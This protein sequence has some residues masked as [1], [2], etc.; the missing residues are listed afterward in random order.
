MNWFWSKVDS[1][2]K[3]GNPKDINSNGPWNST[4]ILNLN[5]NPNCSSIH[6]IFQCE[7]FPQYLF[8]QTETFFKYVHYN[9]T[10]FIQSQ[11]ITVC[12][13]VCMSVGLYTNTHTNTRYVIGVWHPLLPNHCFVIIISR[14]TVQCKERT[15]HATGYNIELHKKKPFQTQ[16]KQ[17]TI[18]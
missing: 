10:M 4:P 15:E 1:Q 13:C 7:K 12:L 3:I 14:R 6:R 18:K 2:V 16:C 17:W 11:W 5:K 8:V 9:L